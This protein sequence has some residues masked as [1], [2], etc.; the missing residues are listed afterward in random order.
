MKRNNEH[1]MT[2]EDPVP[3]IVDAVPA[4]KAETNLS[5]KE[6]R[7]IFK[8]KCED[9]NI[10][11]VEKLFQRFLHHQNKKC[12]KKTFE[13]ENS[14]L[15]PRAMQ[16]LAESIFRH[17][18]IRVVKLAGNPIGD[19]G[20]Q[21][22]SLLLQHSDKIISLDISNCGLGDAGAKLIFG[23]LRTN[24]TL[25]S[26]NIGNS[27]G[28]SRNGLGTASVTELVEMLKENKVLSELSLVMTEMTCDHINMIAGG[29]KMNKTLQ[30]LNVS[31]NNMGSKGAICLTQALTGTQLQEL[32][33]A[34]NH[35]RDDFAPHIANML[36][37]NKAIRVLDVSS[38]SLTQKFIN[39]ISPA[40]AAEDCSLMSLNVSRNP[41]GAKGISSLG[42]ALV[43]NTSLT[44]LNVSAC[45]LSAAGFADFCFDLRRNQTLVSLIALHNAIRDQ[46]ALELANV[47]LE[48]PTLA[49]IDVE[50]CE[51]EDEG[52][53]AMFQAVEK[54][55][56][57]RKMSIKNNLIRNGN[58]IIRAVT[59]NSR[60]CALNIDYNDI[61]YKIYE[62]IL[63]QVAENRK[64]SKHGQHAKNAEEF[65][66]IRHVNEEL[67]DTRGKIVK[68]RES[69]V[70]MNDELDARKQQL[71]M[72]SEQ[73]QTKLGELEKSVEEITA[74]ARDKYNEFHDEAA[75]FN[76]TVS[77]LESEVNQLSMKLA[78]EGE[79]RKAV[80]K[81]MTSV[82]DEIRTKE[83]EYARVQAELEERWRQ[84]KE[85][86]KDARQGVEMAYQMAKTARQ[87]TVAAGAEEEEKREVDES[88]SRKPTKRTS[89]SKSKAKGKTSRA[90]SKAKAPP[91]EP[92]PE[93]APEL[94]QT[95]QTT[96]EEE[97]NEPEQ[98]EREDVAEAPAAAAIPDKS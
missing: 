3:R 17:E 40:I 67:M 13:M 10:K 29:L 75:R 14:A 97:R 65:A 27:S 28:V 19:G 66:K 18:N 20:A 43:S 95:E 42:Q 78:R 90:R 5:E 12:H 86:Y 33:L 82:E 48:H 2:E 81:N 16:V 36:K 74:A 38:N 71:Q 63:R 68:V 34:A 32:Y 39:A 62:G 1:L 4:R 64:L 87:E 60:V 58:P 88:T 55:P 85:K 93:P 73:S 59:E 47:I 46:G 25:M 98:N 91:E 45:K 49:E 51:I 79:R 7:A 83:A 53:L 9:F 77:D 72:G 94:E 92:K 57:L 37:Q 6:L 35:I 61:E 56:A 11:M 76:K 24:K 44:Y 84:V 30:V 41:L 31:S 70:L 8:A 23:S 52:A 80:L 21:F 22:I 69:L 89:R 50:L 15:G 26:L 96:A 54:S